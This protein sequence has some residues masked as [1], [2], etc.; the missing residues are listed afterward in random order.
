V[1]NKVVR[2]KQELDMKQAVGIRLEL[3][4]ILEF[5]DM[6]VLLDRVLTALSDGVRVCTQYDL[7]RRVLQY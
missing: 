7:Y 3:K 1:E 6:R 2:M 5:L 4:D